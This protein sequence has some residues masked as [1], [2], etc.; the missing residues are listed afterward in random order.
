MSACGATTAELVRLTEALRLH[1]ADAATMNA[2]AENLSCAPL[3][4]TRM[5]SRTT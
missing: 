2:I 5:A 3:A 1:Q 4:E